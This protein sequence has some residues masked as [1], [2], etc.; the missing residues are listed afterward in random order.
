MSTRNLSCFSQR[1]RHLCRAFFVVLA[2]VSITT[3]A[4]AAVQPITGTYTGRIIG[5]NTTFV[6][7]NKHVTDWAG[8]LNLRLDSGQDVPIFCIE[9]DVLVRPGDRYQSDGPVLQLPNGCKIRYL[10][11]KYP[12]SSAR[13]AEEAAARQLAIWAFSDNVDLATITGTTTLVR[14]RAIALVNEARS[15]PCPGT[16]PDIPDLTLEP[17]VA[18]AAVGQ[19]VTYTVRTGPGGAGQNVTISVTGPARLENGQQQST[20]TL[21]GQG[22]ARFKVIGSGAGSSTVTITLPYQLRAGTV[23]SHID[24][25]QKTQRLVT[26]DTF[27]LV[28][29]ASAQANWAAQAPQTRTPAPHPAPQPTEEHAQT[30][31]PVVWPELNAIASTLP[32]PVP[33]VASPQLSPTPAVGSPQLSPTRVAAAPRTAGG[34]A[35]TRPR[36]LPNTSAPIHGPRWVDIGLAALLI[37]CG[38]ALRRWKIGR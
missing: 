37:V 11:D 25:N 5:Q 29:T 14:D 9:V 20:L 27:S 3:A 26:A 32:S 33:T 35:P 16:Q 21:D 34:T 24:N 12:A 30:A 7:N 4:F 23:F 8:V 6:R 22:N 2:L 17:P 36:S 13:S 28:A 38:W 19:A 15:A 18:S 10:L 31:T 1:V